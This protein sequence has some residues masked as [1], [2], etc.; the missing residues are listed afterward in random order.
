MLV[1]PCL[2]TQ[3]KRGKKKKK[4]KR[5]RNR[6][7]YYEDLT[8]SWQGCINVLPTFVHSFFC[9]GEIFSFV[10]EKVY[11]LWHNGLIILY[12]YIYIYSRSY[13]GF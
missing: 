2:E 7:C 8:P 13:K 9:V 12:I 1:W 10:L 4:K 5:K 3:K 6:I 11:L